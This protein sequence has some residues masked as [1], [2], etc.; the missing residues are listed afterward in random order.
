MQKLKWPGL[1]RC[2]NQKDLFCERVTFYIINR[3]GRMREHAVSDALN[4]LG[5]NGI[6]EMVLGASVINVI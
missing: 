5:Q 2:L 3:G 4:Q 1:L 6:R